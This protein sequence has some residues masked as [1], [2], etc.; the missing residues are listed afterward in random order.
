MAISASVAVVGLPD[1][2]QAVFPV[3]SM[4]PRRLSSGA[5]PQPFSGSAWEKDAAGDT[6]QRTHYRMTSLSHELKDSF[7]EL[8]VSSQSLVA[9]TASLSD[10]LQDVPDKFDVATEMS[11]SSSENVKVSNTKPRQVYHMTS[12]SHELEAVY[13]EPE[14]APGTLPAK[15]EKQGQEH[16][17]SSFSDELD[18][19]ST[20][21]G[22]TV[23]DEATLPSK[24][25]GKRQ[26]HRMTSLS[27]ELDA[28]YIAQ[29]FEI[30]DE[31]TLPGKVEK[32]G[33]THQMTSLSAKLDAMYT[34]QGF[35]IGGNGLNKKFV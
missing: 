1:F 5:Q 24:V 15:V 25:E 2:G 16:K 33:Q 19:M 35:E 31:G 28:M 6:R 14:E 34:A 18:T 21:R 4:F 22:S 32:K 12:L 20:A 23:G 10:N 13:A 8:D 9:L 17:V 7:E 3:V 11:T 29:G 26:T 30:G 27:A